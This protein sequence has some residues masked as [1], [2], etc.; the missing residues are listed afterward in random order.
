MVGLKDGSGY[1]DGSGS[2]Y[3]DGD[4][5]GYGSGSGSG[6]GYGDGYGD[7]SGYWHVA[8]Q[9]FRRELPTGAKDR[10][11]TLESDGAVICYWRSDQNG[12]PANG[13][14]KTVASAGLVEEI[15]GPLKICTSNALH[16]TFDP[17]KWK[18]KR[19]WLVALIGETQVKEDKIGAL[20]R[21]IICELVP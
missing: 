7:G 5:D 19:I 4:G 16:G 11:A 10:C 17:T 9:A 2:G 3:G 21:E 13:G 20:K 15:K 12:R 6:S 18:G 8:L 14:S 1:G